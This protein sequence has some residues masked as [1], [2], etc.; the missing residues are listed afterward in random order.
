M[1]VL[2]LGFSCAH[3]DFQVKCVLGY[4]NLRLR[5]GNG[6][7]GGRNSQEGKRRVF[8]LDLLS[9]LRMGDKE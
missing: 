3:R 5:N 7:D 9:S 4:Q 2:F 8:R 1:V 6:L